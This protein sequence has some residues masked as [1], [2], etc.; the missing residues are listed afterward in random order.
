MKM[1]RR[2]E[3]LEITDK[4]P[5]YYTPKEYE[6]SLHKLDRIGRYLGGDRATYRALMRLN[7]MPS[8]FLDVGC[9]GGL[10]ALKLS[11]R[12]P[13]SRVVGI[14]ISSEAIAFAKRQ[15][16]CKSRSHGHVNF[17][18]MKKPVL[19]FPANSFDVVMSTLMCH[20]LT[21]DDIVGFLR[22]AHIIAKE[23][24]VINDLHRHW[25]A[26]ASYAVVAPLFFYNRL[27]INDGLLSIKRSFT[28]RDWESYIEKAGIP[29]REA[30]ISWHW[31]FRWVVVID[32]RR[33]L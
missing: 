10:F 31:A 33:S 2:C 22:N 21:D 5:E 24:V 23:A 12:Y 27:V 32:K 4:G 14:D 6:D 20:H 8:S 9:G 11:R 7:R 3:E 15:L 29:S 18:H 1:L 19:D 26:S 16:V 13:Q 25:L 30:T 17:I 28:R